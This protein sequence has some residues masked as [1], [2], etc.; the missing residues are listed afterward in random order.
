MTV[1]SV[2]N[3]FGSVFNITNYSQCTADDFAEVFKNAPENPTY[4]D[5]ML[6]DNGVLGFKEFLDKC[7]IEG[8]LI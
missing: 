2:K 8:I 1:D 7:K 3:K 4:D 6:I 5:L